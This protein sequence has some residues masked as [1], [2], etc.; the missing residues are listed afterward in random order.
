MYP[1]WSPDGRSVLWH[2]ERQDGYYAM[3]RSADASL[4][5]RPLLTTKG[6]Y[7]RASWHAGGKVI[8]TYGADKERHDIWVFSL[9][10][11]SQPEPVA[12]TEAN[13]DNGKLAP[14]GRLIA[15]ESDESGR[16]EIYVRP[17]P[18]PAD[19]VTQVTRDGG[20][21][22]HWSS[23]S[24]HIYFSSGSRAMVVDI[25]PGAPVVATRPTLVFDGLPESWDVSG[26]GKTYAAIEPAAAPELMVALNWLDELKRRVPPIGRN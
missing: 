11:P 18:R 5:E 15:Y 21:N 19:W 12:T 10:N 23:D 25:T 16:I 26:D 6:Q 20:A 1:A 3:T 17:Y 22:P 14:N 13:E 2:S 8:A 9:D 4:P 24:R 7:W